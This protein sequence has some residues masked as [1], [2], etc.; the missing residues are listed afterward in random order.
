[1]T[2]TNNE[3]NLII[4]SLLKRFKDY[5]IITYEY[6]SNFI[7]AYEDEE[8]SYDGFDLKLSDYPT[9]TNPYLYISFKIQSFIYNKLCSLATED[10]DILLTLVSDKMRI[11]NMIA[12]KFNFTDETKKEDYLMDALTSFN[13][14]D[15]IDTHITRYVIARIKGVPYETK[16]EQITRVEAK[17]ETVEVGKTKKGKKKKNRE[18]TNSVPVIVPPVVEEKTQVIESVPTPEPVVVLEPQ[19]KEETA[20][21]LCLKNCHLAKGSKEA[22]EFVQTFLNFGTY[23]LIDYTNNKEYAMYMLLRFGFVNENY[24]SLREIALITNLSFKNILNFEKYTVEIMRQ[25]LNAKVDYYY[26]L[27]T[28][29]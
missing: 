9:D 27:V 1:M 26:K 14:D 24:Y 18:F 29:K 28:E 2:I 16:K 20:Y 17:K 25:H 19:T 23:D 12:R 5:E 22:D 3:K 10:A 13:G 8:P 15:S 11:V 6:I 21:E 7:K 4:D